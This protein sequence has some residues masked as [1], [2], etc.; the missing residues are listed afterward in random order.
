MKRS[1]IALAVLAASGAALAQSSV[2]LFGVM[3][4]TV[5]VGHGAITNKTQLTNSGNTTTRLGFKGTEDLG[6][7]LNASFWLETGIN[8][9]DGS[10]QATNLNNTNA[11]LTPAGGITFNRRSTVSLSNQFGEI[12][13]GRD[14]TP[15]FWNYVWF[16]P[17]TYN[18]VGGIATVHGTIAGATKVRASNSISYFTPATL[19]GFYGQ[20][21]HYFGEQP[22][23]TPTSSDGTGTSLRVGYA[24]GPFNVAVATSQTDYLAPGNI[25]TT[26]VGASYDFG[27]VKLFG[28]YDQ[29]KIS[30]G[31]TGKGWLVG[32]S[33]PVGVGQL[34]ASYSGYKGNLTSNDPRLTK[35]AVGYVYNLS[36]RTVLYATIAHLNNKN[37]S[38]VALNGATTAAN[39]GSSGLDLGL[40]TS[41]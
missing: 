30:G 27:A 32:L 26:N 23:G 9:D 19:G 8:N 20:L 40:R 6:G 4:A 38:A 37:G 17:F 2:T 12:R 11:G 15:H 28:L 10:G 18:G 25:K 31:T 21:M 14:Y 22:S 13:L 29:D 7:G 5:A 36:K 24:K 35:L 39:S 16:D 1:L 3:D 34:R 41:F 33:A